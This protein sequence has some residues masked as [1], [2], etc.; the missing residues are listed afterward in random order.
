MARA[1]NF[2]F[3]HA[4]DA[5][6]HAADAPLA[7]TLASACGDAWAIAVPLTLLSLGL[8][9]MF[10][11]IGSLSR[12]EQGVAFAATGLC[13]LL[14]GVAYVVAAVG[15]RRRQAWAVELG[16][17][18]VAGHAAAIVL[19]LALAAIAPSG[20]PPVVR[21]PAFLSAI[22]FPASLAF[23]L[24]TRKARLAA[25]GFTQQH[26]FSPLIGGAVEPQE[27]EAVEAEDADEAP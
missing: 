12:L 24:H 16:P 13:G 19:A 22:F 2:Y 18:A 8:L 7:A 23:L 20:A 4:E 9:A 6:R 11:R 1:G 15:L 5:E 26:G 21:L 10:W 3:R 25:R 27:A 14:P 17:L